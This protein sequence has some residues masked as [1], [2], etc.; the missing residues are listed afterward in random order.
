MQIKTALSSPTEGLSLR[1]QVINARED[2]GT[3]YLYTLLMFTVSSFI[4]V[5]L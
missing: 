4:L 5:K 2:A 1:K 3:G